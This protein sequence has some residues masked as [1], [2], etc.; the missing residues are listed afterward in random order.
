MAV[1]RSCK[2]CKKKFKVKPYFVRQG[3]GIYCSRACHFKGLKKGEHKICEICGKKVYRAP[4]MVERSK[5]GKYF[6]SKSCQTLWR[7]QLY[8]GDKHANYVDGK[9]SYRSVL[10]RHGVK[11]FCRLCRIKDFRVI[12]VHHVDKNRKNNSVENLVYLCHNCHHLVHRYP[13]ERDKLMVPI[14]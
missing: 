5:S 7:N 10:N 13:Q 1:E 9:S 14:A 2:I 8:I 6:C 11:K 12:A 4:R 3:W